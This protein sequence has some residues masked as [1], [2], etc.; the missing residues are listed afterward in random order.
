[1][2][3]NLQI[4]NNPDQSLDQVDPTPQQEE[5]LAETNFANAPDSEKY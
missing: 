1:M 3:D 5:C 2:T 4:M